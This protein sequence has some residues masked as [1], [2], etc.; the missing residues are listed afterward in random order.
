MLRIISGAFDKHNR[1]RKAEGLRERLLVEQTT[2]AVMSAVM[3]GTN[4]NILMDCSDNSDWHEDIH[5]D[6]FRAA[7]ITIVALSTSIILF[8]LSILTS[9]IIGQILNLTES[10]EE[11]KEL[12]ENIDRNAGYM[13]R[14]P[15]NFIVFGFMFSFVAFFTYLYTNYVIPTKSQGLSPAGWALLLLTVFTIVSI[16][17]LARGLARIISGLHQVREPAPDV[18]EVGLERV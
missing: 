17:F 18:E 3:V 2:H 9:A 6:G 13:L 14:V 10:D 16:V 11:A 1:T 8:M 15:Y 5:S 4:S 7:G 12:V